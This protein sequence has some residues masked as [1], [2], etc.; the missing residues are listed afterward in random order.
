MELELLDLADD[1]LEGIAIRA[2]SGLALLPTKE[3]TTRRVGGLAAVYN[4]YSVAGPRNAREVIRPGAFTESLRSGRDIFA[5]VNHN[6]SQLLGRTGNGTLRLQDAADGLHY[7]IDLP[8]TSY[9]RD[10]AALLERGDAVGASFGMKLGRGDAVWTSD[11]SGPV[12][13]IRRAQLFEVSPMLEAGAYPAATS[14]LRALAAWIEQGAPAD[15]QPPPPKEADP[16][17]AAALEIEAARLAAQRSA[18]AL[19]GVDC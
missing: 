14:E 13:E 7:E 11:K 2:A 3:G 17:T 19:R 15:E 4:S 1:G 10:L 9:A 5:F 12:R 8:D 18:L 6:R 16:Q